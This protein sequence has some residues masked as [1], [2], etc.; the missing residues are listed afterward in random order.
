M[1][2]LP[3]GW[4]TARWL[5]AAI[6]L[7]LL[8]LVAFGVLPYDLRPKDSHAY[9]VVNATQ[10]YARSGLGE[11]DAFF[12][13]PV[14]AQLLAP[15]HA[16]QFEVF[17][18]VWGALSLAALTA[19]GALY[20]LVIPGVIEDLVRG[21]IHVL[22]ALAIVAGFRFP[23]TWS[24]VLLTKVTPGVGLL[25]FA[26]RRE[27][28]A[29]LQV[30]AVT[31]AI[32][33]ISLAVGGTG[34][35]VDWIRILTTSAQDPLN[36]VYLGLAAPPLLVRVPMAVLIVG[37]GAL[38]D[39]RWTVPI[40]ALLA[41]PV[42]WP[43]GFALLAA[44]PPLWLADR[45]ARATPGARRPAS[46]LLEQEGMPY[47]SI[48]DLPKAQVDQYSTHQK[49]AFLEAFNNALEEYKDEGRAFA[50]AH[51]AA[52]RAPRTEPDKERSKD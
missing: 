15:M 36:Y 1:S 27:W 6:G 49:H 28:S 37:W 43:S 46:V 51:A 47:D 16:L 3:G 48:S 8:A 44:V 33:A 42:L 11:V 34:P 4:R 13:A 12:Y 5:L 2:R 19:M 22:L 21:N 23:G 17:R 29:L 18:L 45:R 40:A 41:L 30:T 39:R 52:Q 10:P 25:W 24:A 38:T 9:W 26:I 14:V 31:A 7:G 20:A 32:V 50:V 35:W